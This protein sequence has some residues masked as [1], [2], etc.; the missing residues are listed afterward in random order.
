LNHIFLII[1]FVL[2]P[3]G[4]GKGLVFINGFNLGR[5]WPLAGPQITLYIPKEILK[6][7][8][9]E[10]TM[11]ELQTAPDNGKITLTDVANLDGI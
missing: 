9:N 11:L 7:G 10:I 3:S 6:V 8:I 1:L 5:Y 2:D 4:W